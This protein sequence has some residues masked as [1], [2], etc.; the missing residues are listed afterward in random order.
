MGQQLVDSLDAK[1]RDSTVA[2][3][4]KCRLALGRLSRRLGRKPLE[5]T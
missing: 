2:S 1:P 4:S 5:L 3:V